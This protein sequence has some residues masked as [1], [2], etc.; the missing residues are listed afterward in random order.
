MNNET[1]STSNYK[2]EWIRKY[3]A[4]GRDVSTKARNKAKNMAVQWVREHHPEVW[5]DLMGNARQIVN[6]EARHGQ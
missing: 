5:K 4:E 6:E 3:R 1:A 2:A